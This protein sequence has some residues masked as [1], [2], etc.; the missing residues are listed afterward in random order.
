MKNR[1]ALLAASILLA[2][3]VFAQRNEQRNEQHGEQRPSHEPNGPRANQGRI[4]QPPPKRESRSARPEPERKEGG[5]VN[6]LPHVNNDHW[7]GHDRPND[8]RYHVDRPFEHGHF[9]HFGP[10]YRYRVERFDRDRHIFWFPGSFSFQIAPWDWAVAADWC[11]DCPDDDFVVYEDSDHDGWYMLYNV[12]TG[13]YVHV[14][15]MGM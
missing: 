5:R 11:W 2:V 6:S 14:Q 4:P 10:T 9:E 15:Y 7:Y 1:I 3:P 12:H 8:K 13:V